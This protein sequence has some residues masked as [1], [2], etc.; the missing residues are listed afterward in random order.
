M[1]NIFPGQHL[2]HIGSAGWISDHSGAAANQGNGSVP[3]HLKPFHQ[4]Q[5]HK[6]TG[7]K[8]VRRTVIPN[9]ENCLSVIDQFLDFRLIRYLSNKASGHQ[10]VVDRHIYF[11][12][13]FLVQGTKSP[14]SDLD[15]GRQKRG[16]T[17]GSPFPHE[18]GLMPCQHTA[19]Q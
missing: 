11:L 4:S 16:T 1:V 13:S 3:R 2:S 19:T 10:F 6:M 17:S 15:R 18:N 7:S 8:A 9:I 5:R 12:L 14:L